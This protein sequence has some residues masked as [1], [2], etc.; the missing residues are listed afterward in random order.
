MGS[1]CIS[2][3]IDANPVTLACEL[4]CRRFG[5]ERRSA[6]RH[7][8]ER[9]AR[10]ADEPGEGGQVDDGTAVRAAARALAQRRERQLGAEKDADQ[11]DAAQPMPVGKGGFLE[12]HAEKDLAL[13]TRMSSLPKRLTMAASA[14][15][16]SSSRVT[17]RWV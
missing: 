6:L 8:V 14:A 11:I 9:V 5:E 12:A 15:L 4:E 17:S 16:Q 13:L 2:R 1:A 7:R 10:R 3:H